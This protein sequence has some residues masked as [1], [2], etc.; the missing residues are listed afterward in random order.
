MKI[1]GLSSLHF[2]HTFNPLHEHTDSLART[3]G[4]IAAFDGMVLDI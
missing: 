2:A 1:P 3:N 4:F